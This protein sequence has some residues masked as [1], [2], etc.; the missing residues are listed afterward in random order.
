MTL[1][2]LFNLP[3]GYTERTFVIDDNDV[4]L[5]V[6]TK[7]LCAAGFSSQ[8]DSFL[9]A[10]EALERLKDGAQ[11]L[12]DFIFLDLNMPGMDG[13]HFLYEFSQLPEPIQRN[14]K[15][16]VLTSSMSSRDKEKALANGHVFMF[17]SKPISQQKV[18]EIIEEI[19]GKK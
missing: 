17:I 4:D 7:V 9:R 15:V 13:F 5:F 2:G 16:I 12:P 8:I 14:V 19:G 10:E 11:S 1:G 3:M 18:M 6:N